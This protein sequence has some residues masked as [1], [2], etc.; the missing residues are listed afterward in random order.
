MQE[1]KR[2]TLWLNAECSVLPLTQF[3][4][5]CIASKGCSSHPRDFV[6]ENEEPKI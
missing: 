1:L 6:V 2:N 3:S 4:A 5:F